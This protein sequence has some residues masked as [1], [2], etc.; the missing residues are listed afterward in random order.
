M[1]LLLILSQI[2]G[3]L[4]GFTSCEVNQDHPEII[5][6]SN[7][8][9]FTQSLD[10]YF[11]GQGLT[12]QIDGIQFGVQNST[13]SS[14]STA[15]QSFPE[16]TIFIDDAAQF[17]W[18]N[19]NYQ[20]DLFAALV[21]ENNEYY[22]YET[23][24]KQKQPTWNKLTYSFSNTQTAIC[25][26][27]AYI[28]DSDII[29]SC[30]TRKQGFQIFYYFQRI[31]IKKIFTKYLPGVLIQSPYEYVLGNQ[32]EFSYLQILNNQEK[33]FYAIVVH[34]NYFNPETIVHIF[35]VEFQRSFKKPKMSV[36][37]SNHHDKAAYGAYVADIDKIYLLFFDA[38]VVHDFTK[39]IHKNIMT[40][41]DQAQGMGAYRELYTN[42]EYNLFITVVTKK[43][44]LFYST[45]N[46]QSIQKPQLP[47]D[48]DTNK[49]LSVKVSLLYSIITNSASFVIYE[50]RYL[51]TQEKIQYGFLQY[52]QLPALLSIFYGFGSKF[53]VYQPK[54][55]TFFQIQI[56]YLYSKKTFTQNY[57][58]LNQISIQATSYD[59]KQCVC[60][61][62]YE[63]L[64]VN[65]M[66]N[67]VALTKNQTFSEPILLFNSQSKLLPLGNQFFGSNLQYKI[68]VQQK[69]EKEFNLTEILQP[70][71]TLLYINQ[72]D[73]L[74]NKYVVAF[75]YTYQV[76]ED[77]Y[78][79]FTQLTT[80]YNNI[81][82]E[83]CK[84]LACQKL[85]AIILDDCFTTVA[86]IA[87]F[88]ADIILYIAVATQKEIFIFDYNYNKM[89]EEFKRSKKVSNIAK[90]IPPQII[91]QSIN[92][93]QEALIILTNTPNSIICLDTLLIHQYT[94][95]GYGQNPRQVF[96]NPY[97][98]NDTYFVDNQFELLMIQNYKN[99]F[100][101]QEETQKRYVYSIFVS[102]N[103]PNSYKQQQINIG[104]V[105]QG[106]YLIQ[107]STKNQTLIQNVYFYPYEYLY[108]DTLFTQT[109][110][111]QM[112]NLTS[113][114]ISLQQPFVSGISNNDKFYVIVF[115]TQTTQYQLVI[116]QPSISEYS[117][118]YSILNLA[119]LPTN[120]N[121]ITINREHNQVHDSELNF[122]YDL[123]FLTSNISQTIE[124]IQVFKEATLLY[125]PNIQQ[126]RV[127]TFEVTVIAQNNFNVNL[128]T[129]ASFTRQIKSTRQEIGIIERENQAF[130]P[131]NTLGCIFYL[132][133]N[134][135]D[136]FF[137]YVTNY[138]S[139]NKIGYK[140]E[141]DQEDIFIDCLQKDKKDQVINNSIVQPIIRQQANFS[142][143]YTSV[144]SG[145][146]AGQDTVQTF[147]QSGRAM[148]I[149][150]E[151]E[152]LYLYTIPAFI[153]ANCI[154]SFVT[155][156][157]GYLITV[158]SNMDDTYF[159]YY[160]GTNNQN[161]TMLGFSAYN[162]LN[163][164]SY[165]NL[166]SAQFQL[167]F[168]ALQYNEFVLT[169]KV[170][171]TNETLELLNPNQYNFNYPFKS[172]S[173][174]VV[175]A[176]ELE[177]Q[178]YTRDKS[179]SNKQN[180]SQFLAKM[181]AG[182]IV[183]Y[184]NS[185]LQFFYKQ[186]SQFG[187][188]QQILPNGI[189]ILSVNSISIGWITNTYLSTPFLISTTYASYLFQVTLPILQ[190]SGQ[191]NIDLIYKLISFAKYKTLGIY[192]G[193]NAI[194]GFF[195]TDSNEKGYPEYVFGLY[196]I[197]TLKD[198]TQ[199][200]TLKVTFNP[201]KVYQ[202]VGSSVGFVGI[203]NL[204]N[205]TISNPIITN[206]Q[207]ILYQVNQTQ[208]QYLFVSNLIKITVNQV[209]CINTQTI[210]YSLGITQI[211]LI[212]YNN[213][214]SD[215]SRNSFMITNYYPDYTFWDTEKRRRNFWWQFGVGA[216]MFFII[217]GV[218]TFLCVNSNK[219]VVYQER[220]L[221]SE[222]EQ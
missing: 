152:A 145:I 95:A 59:G 222:I 15:N 149:L 24:L 5:Y 120:L 17:N 109:A 37:H 172:Y 200:L 44:L 204:T 96:T 188:Y 67:F 163:N 45:S 87:A 185:I 174:F 178:N 183:L 76:D 66:F 134:P 64:N 181:D 80:N 4:M 147:I 220:I 196:G 177:R 88:K 142:L 55:V 54:Q 173:L 162:L 159:Y 10:N 176:Q 112:I 47:S 70:N 77:T 26:N 98:F 221:Q 38:L 165:P 39:K 129:V 92:F 122:N 73:I 7:S 155:Y 68:E 132:N 135:A 166:I 180:A 137:G 186:I 99:N 131:I 22:V 72:V 127:A 23:S 6:P 182:I 164:Q 97:I 3:I 158:C 106:I 123:L 101:I 115:N 133:I 18:S 116:L 216:I 199:D 187:A 139:I 65:E 136:Y 82:I 8:N 52:T 189:E 12:Y 151:M 198:F 157:P 41:V 9:S 175:D 218:L 206:N 110:Q 35:K 30:V 153:D 212:A 42:G 113:F 14:Q 146:I 124:Q 192:C 43:G 140:Y 210:K 118:I 203:Q 213:F 86:G 214:T 16:N 90:E 117:Q 58:V 150:F 27:V 190:R 148:Y 205:Y 201:D 28:F 84:F 20:Q 78:I 126:N 104:I 61:F 160:N 48:F 56:P 89:H 215:F 121:I 40:V 29:V 217:I 94:I 105:R 51:L 11:H 143:V 202:H 193:G 169:V 71:T 111:F 103:Y 128:P 100:D 211:E 74:V 31:V 194:V 114:N 1:I 19:P 219:I 108:Y 208:F 57:N 107:T 144:T 168:L 53:V 50:N 49:K 91:I 171:A 119:Q 156:D 85:E 209:E 170:N 32:L 102:F 167:N 130:S 62:N 13:T 81:Q 141:L 83:K 75:T 93:V 25:T 69:L 191:P 63:L 125:T 21:I 46:L 138:T 207:T 79:V 197:P 179:A 161:R 33:E 60:T 195:Y 34:A 154:F 184:Q 36:L 2:R